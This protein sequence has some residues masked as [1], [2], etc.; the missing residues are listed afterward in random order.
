[1]RPTTTDDGPALRLTVRLSRIG[2]T[3]TVRI[4]GLGSNTVYSITAVGD[5]PTLVDRPETLDLLL[6]PARCDVHALGESY[7]T[8]L[9]GLVVALG[10]AEPRPYV[11]TPEP[12]LRRDIEAFAV[13]T[14][15]AG[16]D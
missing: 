1:M 10:D 12:A 6:V 11:L 7:R 5:L 9:I 14:C 4:T 16:G 8:S 3:D 13:D 2:G 15:L